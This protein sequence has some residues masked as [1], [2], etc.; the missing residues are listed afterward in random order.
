MIAL[1]LA[2]SKGTIAWC[3][4]LFTGTEIIPEKLKKLWKPMQKKTMLT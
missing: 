2:K 1:R 3:F 4:H